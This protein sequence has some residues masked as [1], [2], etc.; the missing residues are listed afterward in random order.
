MTQSYRDRKGQPVA[1]S[2][3]ILHWF[4]GDMRFYFSRNEEELY[5]K[6]TVQMDPVICIDDRAFWRAAGTGIRQRK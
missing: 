1:L 3:R 6:E 4:D 5:G 2:R